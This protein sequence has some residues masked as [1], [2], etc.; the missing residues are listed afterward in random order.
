[1]TSALD[2]DEFRLI[3]AIAD[4]RSLVGA[5][6]ALGLNHSTVF[7]RLATIES[8][9]GARLFE[10][11]RTGY[12]PTE[13]GEEMIGLANTMAES[14][15]EFERRVAG[16]DARPTGEL[17][18]TA[19]DTVAMR[20]LPPIL[21]R[22]RAVNPGVNVELLIASQTLNLSRR[23]ADVAIRAGNDPPE[24]L[25][26]RRICAIRW[27]VYCT[28]A[29]AAEYGA[30][31][32][33]AAPWIGFSDAL[34]PPRAKRWVDEK[35][36]ARRQV[37][38]VNS[39]LTMSEMAAARLGATLLPCFIGDPHAGLVRVGAPIPEL[40]VDLW[41]PTHADLRHSARVRAFIELAGAELA[42][43]RALLE[44]L[45]VEAA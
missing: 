45:S 15:L 41:L 44:G 38:A 3:K 16:R 1:M 5:A 24:S 6:E 19:V 18:V 31:T 40:D 39:V 27:A 2:W 43:Q 13:A 32:V 29:I 22:F 23:D 34:A 30:R 36:G 11:S 26:G 10:R 17:R 7:R 21:A 33:A 37:C 14:I 42:A 35:V 8:D 28:P 25:V 4:A 20:L 9:V 12:Q